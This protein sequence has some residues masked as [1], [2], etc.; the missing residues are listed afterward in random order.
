MLASFCKRI[1]FLAT[2]S[3]QAGNIRLFSHGS[4]TTNNHWR[5]LRYQADPVY[6]RKVLDHALEYARNRKLVDPE[7]HNKKKAEHRDFMT[8]KR[9][10]KDYRRLE[11]LQI[12]VRQS[13][14]GQADLPWKAYRPRFYT[15]RITHLCAGC[16]LQDRKANLWWSSTLEPAKYLC[17]RCWSK[18]GWEQT[19]PEHFE[20]AASYKEFT[21]CAKELGL[22]KP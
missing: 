11:N 4:R 3:N 9:T 17:A 16:N 5:R 2:S 13:G 18:L 1:Y 14:W 8:K 19:C 12:W 10:D 22:S 7:F 20:N 6:R 21:A 15:E